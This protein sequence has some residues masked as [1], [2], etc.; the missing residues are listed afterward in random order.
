VSY[1]KPKAGTTALLKIDTEL[2]SRD[3]CIQLLEAKGV[4]FTP[5]SAMDIEGYVRIGYANNPDVLK[6]G[7]VKVSEFLREVR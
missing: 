6:V 5:G 1:I 3:F 2:S 4:M 7:L